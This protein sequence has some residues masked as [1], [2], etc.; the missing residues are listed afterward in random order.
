MDL[1]KKK[2]SIVTGAS[3]GLG[4]SISEELASRGKNLILVALPNE[5]LKTLG[6]RLSQRY[7]VQVECY[8]TDFSKPNS[9]YEFASW[10]N[11]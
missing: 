11:H 2:F 7:Q 9:V 1:A 6:A 10:V 4:Q 3:Q 8:E 5:E